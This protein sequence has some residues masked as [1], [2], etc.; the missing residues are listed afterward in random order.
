MIETILTL[1]CQSCAE[2]RTDFNK[3]HKAQMRINRQGTTH[4]RTCQA[5]VRVHGK[6]ASSCKN[7]CFALDKYCSLHNFTYEGALIF[8]NY[9]PYSKNNWLEYKQSNIPGAGNG[10][11]ALYPFGPCS[12]VTWYYG[13]IVPVVDT[14]LEYNVM[15]NN[16]WTQ[17]FPLPVLGKGQGAFLNTSRGSEYKDNCV[18]SYSPTHSLIFIKIK[19]KTHVKVGDEL[20]ICYG[21]GFKFKKKEP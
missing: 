7:N 13:E 9:H 10:I 18:F 3:A 17:G 21:Q 12:I 20:F 4:L 11:F 6:R 5:I 1:P 19:E 8:G 16:E 14:S 15:M 2:D